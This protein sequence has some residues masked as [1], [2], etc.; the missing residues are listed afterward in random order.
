MCLQ[1]MCHKH[2][3]CLVVHTDVAKP[4]RKKEGQLKTILCSSLL[5]SS[6]QVASAVIMIFRKIHNMDEQRK[7]RMLYVYNLQDTT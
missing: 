4:L 5:L 7:Q 6:P 1:R 3:Q 2:G